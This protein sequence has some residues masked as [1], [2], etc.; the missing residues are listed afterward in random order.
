MTTLYTIGY[1]ALPPA[2]LLAIAQALDA[3]VIDCR[4]TPVSRIKGYHKSQLQALLGARYEAR[5]SELGGIRN[6]VCHTSTAGI[7]HLRAD[8][9]AG[10]NLILMCME[11]A[12]GDCH[13]HQLICAPHFPHALH[14]YEDELIEAHELQ[15]ALDSPDEDASYPIAACLSARMQG[16]A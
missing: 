10:R 6:G 1:Q 9:A 4:K 14:I 5:G 3:T 7:E 13:R 8:L 16:A 11:H 15:S 12:P 2:R